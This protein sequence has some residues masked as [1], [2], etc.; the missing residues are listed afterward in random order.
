MIDELSA[1]LRRIFATI[2]ARRVQCACRHWYAGCSTSLRRNIPARAWALNFCGPLWYAR[3][4]QYF[5]DIWCWLTFWL[6]YLWGLL[7]QC[8]HK[9]PL[10]HFA[11][12]GQLAITKMHYHDID[13]MAYNLLQ[14]P[15]VFRI[16]TKA[17]TAA[18]PTRQTIPKSLHVMPLV[19][20]ATTIG[21]RH[22]TMRTSRT[23]I[24]L[25]MRFHI[26]FSRDFRESLFS[27]AVWDISAHYWLWLGIL[28]WFHIMPRW[29]GWVTR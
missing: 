1:P 17:M 29:W 22:A 13:I 28:Y 26:D 15:A 27:M 25:M 4:R 24:L 7:Y 20:A 16:F 8:S 2:V 19:T 5:D 6:R 9:F 23:R 21:S 3:V 14:P 12:P 18:V 11:V 10:A